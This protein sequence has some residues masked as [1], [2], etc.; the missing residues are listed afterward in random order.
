VDKNKVSLPLY[1]RTRKTGDTILLPG[2]GRSKIKKIFIDQK[3][4]RKKRDR[5]PVIVDAKG[6]VIWIVGVKSS[7]FCQSEEE[8][9]KK[10]IINADCSRREEL[11]HEK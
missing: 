3:I 2:G 1:V 4:S 5:I 11:I 8:E 7:V 9:R 6:Q 10:L